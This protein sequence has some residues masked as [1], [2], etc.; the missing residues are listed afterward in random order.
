MPLLDALPPRNAFCALATNPGF[1][2][3]QALVVGK[4]TPGAVECKRKNK[5]RCSLRGKSSPHLRWQQKNNRKP[6]DD[7]PRVP[8]G[9]DSLYF[10]RLQSQASE[11]FTACGARGSA[12]LCL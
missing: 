1:G 6:E 8:A 5:M 2:S 9:Q 4:V 12:S 11:A 7:A 10:H 3:R